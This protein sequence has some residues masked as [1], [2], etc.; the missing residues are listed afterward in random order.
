MYQRMSNKFRQIITQG[1]GSLRVRQRK[2][3]KFIDPEK[4]EKMLFDGI[5]D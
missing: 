2:I 3:K 5:R 4:K 1:D